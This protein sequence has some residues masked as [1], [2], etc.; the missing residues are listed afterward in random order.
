MPKARRQVSTQEQDDAPLLASELVSRVSDNK[1]MD[2]VNHY[3]IPPDYALYAPLEACR[4]DRPRLGFVALSEH[5]LNAGGT[6][7]LHP[8]FVAVLNYFDLAPLQL[9]PNG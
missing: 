3:R 2:I 6:I 1:L 5:I 4:A 7:L 9:A 8:F